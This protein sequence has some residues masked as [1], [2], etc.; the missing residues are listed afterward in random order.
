M[1]R[2]IDVTDR[3]LLDADSHLMETPGWLES[4]AD[5]T[6]RERLGELG[7]ASGGREAADHIA[8]AE[9]RMADDVAT[10]EL[11]RNGIGGAYGWSALG[12]ISPA[13]RARVLDL[14]GFGAQLVFSTLASTQ[15]LASDDP[16]VVYGGAAAHNRGIVEFCSVDERLLPVGMVPL[17]DV[18]SAL[19]CLHEALALGCGAIWVPHTT[20]G[21]RSP[22]HVD[23]EPFWATL[24]EAGVPFVLHI[25]GGRTLSHRFHDNG[26]PLPPDFVGGGENIRAK[27]VIAIHH[28]PETFLACLVLDGV[29]ERHPDLRA[30]AIELGASWV[31][32]FMHRLDAAKASFGRNEPLLGDLSMA[33]SDYVRRQIRFTPFAFDD[34]GALIEQTDPCL[35]LFSTDYPHPEGSRDP[36]GKFDAFLDAHDIGPEA[37]EAFFSANFASL[38]GPAARTWPTAASSAHAT[39]VGG[40]S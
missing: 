20:A 6:T 29:F 30:G 22:A 31:P 33:P 36:L 35:Y 17:Q 25:G 37:R 38:F 32:G 28:G 27:D 26:R 4:Y 19:V 2:M 5:L 16:V 39:T 34:V 1:R 12:A 40:A 7:L 13:E 24:A 14:V 15:F 3:I 9:R 10:A 8:A 11:E 18:K 21:G 23:M